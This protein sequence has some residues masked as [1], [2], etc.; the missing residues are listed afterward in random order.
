MNFKT[1]LANEIRQKDFL[2]VSHR[3]EWGGNI[4]QN[5]TQSAGLAHR[6]GAD[7]VEIDVCRS[8]DG[9]YYLFH[10]GH[11]R[12]LLQESRPFSQL[13][14]KEIEAMP[15]YNSID[16][17]SGYSINRLDA[18]L[19]W[20]PSDFVINVDR[21]YVYFDDE[22]FFR[23]LQASGKVEQ[24]FLKA[25]AKEE[26]LSNFS[27]YGQGLHFIPI[28]ASPAEFDF[29]QSYAS[30]IN[31]LGYEVVFKDGAELDHYDQFMGS[32]KKE[33]PLWMANAIHLGQSHVLAGGLT[34]DAALFQ[35]GKDWEA[36]AA[37]GFTAIQTDWPV[38]LN[39]FREERL[40]HVK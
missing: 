21:A 31:T 18:F 38:L 7:I 25:P 35:E 33:S 22:R 9:E 13:T 27:Q 4:I 30:K 2:I 20:L 19:E 26:Y 14:S 5:T 24:L 8:M 6:M 11:E 34:D 29:Y 17:V 23:I 1:H 36:M 3:G 37:A 12:T 39:A 15:V 28:V 10:D 32:E 40:T 16:A